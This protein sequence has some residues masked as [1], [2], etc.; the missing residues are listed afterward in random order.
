[1]TDDTAPRDLGVLTCSL[2]IARP[3]AFAVALSPG[4]IRRTESRAGAVEG[5]GTKGRIPPVITL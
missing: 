1:M 5:G 2:D 4:A 3:R